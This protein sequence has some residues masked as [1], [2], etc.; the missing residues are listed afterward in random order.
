MSLINSGAPAYPFTARSGSVFSYFGIDVADDYDW[1]EDAGAVAVE[2][3]VRQQDELTRGYMARLPHH[4][5]IRQRLEQLL[6]HEQYS[7]PFAAGSYVYYYRKS[8]QQNQ[9]VLY[10]QAGEEDPEVFLDVNVTFPEGVTSPAQIQFSRDGSLAACQLSSGGSDWRSVVIIRS[11]DRTILDDRL[12]GVKFSALSWKGNEGFYYTCYNSPGEAGGSGGRMGFARLCYHRV[13]TLQEDD[14]VVFDGGSEPR[15]FIMAYLSEDEHFLVIGTAMS[16]TGN[17]LFIQGLTSGDG[18]IQPVIQGFETRTSILCSR[19]SRLYILTDLEAPNF[20]L[21]TVDA[22]NP[23]PEN[24]VDLVAETTEVLTA[25]TGGNMLFA[26][27]LRDASTYV[28]QYTLEGRFVILQQGSLLYSDRQISPSIRW[29]MFPG[30]CRTF[31]MTAP[32]S[33]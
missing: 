33:R 12:T 22:A 29:I 20:R 1:L 6:D 10:R 4:D 15:R 8:R 17:D 28:I 27:Y 23:R 21:V 7:N 31:P 32:G 11:A 18:P 26:S 25:G 24:W 19:G 30:R 13:G 9:P 3:W 2:D 16:A 5:R 14:I